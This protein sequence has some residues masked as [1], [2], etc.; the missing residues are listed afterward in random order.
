MN[1]SRCFLASVMSILLQM[2]VF[3][4]WHHFLTKYRKIMVR[5]K[6]K[7]VSFLRFLLESTLLY[8]QFSDI[9][10]Q[11][12]ESTLCSLVEWRLQAVVLYYSGTMT[13]CHVLT[14]TV[15]AGSRLPKSS[16][17][18][19]TAEMSKTAPDS[20]SRLTLEF[21]DEPFSAIKMFENFSSA[22]TSPEMNRKMIGNDFFR[23]RI[24]FWALEIQNS[25]QF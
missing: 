9:L 21:E 2:H 18:V 11:L 24:D 13:V 19:K 23:P 20:P 5:P 22:E 1:K 12:L 16:K 14:V 8:P 10:F 7:L 4:F 17:M 25:C 15:Q 3:P 6:V